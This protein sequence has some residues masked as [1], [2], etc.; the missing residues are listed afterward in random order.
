VAEVAEE[1]SLEIGI[2]LPGDAGRVEFDVTPSQ[3]LF[4]LDRPAYIEALNAARTAE[5]FA[6][7]EGAAE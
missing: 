4:C 3:L 2:L 5:T 1:G 7:D 6:A